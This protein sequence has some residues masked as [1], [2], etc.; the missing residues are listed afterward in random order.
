MYTDHNISACKLITKIN[1][2]L[3]NQGVPL[4]LPLANLVPPQAKS[5]PI[6]TG[7][8]FIQVQRNCP[9]KPPCI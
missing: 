5:L 7:L 9:D 2:T 4:I 8:K 6:R 3:L 1:E